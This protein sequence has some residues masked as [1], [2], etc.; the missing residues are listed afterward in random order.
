MKIAL[1]GTRGV[2][3]AYSGFETAIENIGPRLVARGH[4]VVVYCRP[5]MVERRLATYKGMHLVH[6][7]TIRTKHL[8]TFAHTLLSTGHMVTVERPDV[9]LY[10]IVGNS[11]FTKLSRLANV[12]AIIN[13]DGLD[14]LR[15]KWSPPAKAYLRWAERNAARFAD[16][17]ITDSSVVQDIYRRDYHADTVFIPYGAD[18]DGVD[19]GQCLESLGLQPRGYIL[20]VGRLEP[21]N[22][23]H[24]LVEAFAELHTDLRLV[25]VGDAPYA[26]KYAEVL[27]KLAASDPRVLLAGPI[28]GEGYRE[29]ARNA[30]LFVV[31]SE[32]GGTHPV[33][34][35]AMMA[36]NCVVVN[37][38]LPN[39]EVVGEAAVG[40]EGRRGALALTPVLQRLLDQPDVVEQY[41]RAAAQ[42]AQS[43]YSWDVVTDSYE[44]LAREVV[45]RHRAA[46]EGAGPGI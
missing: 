35:E 14:S 40:Y 34:I 17:V 2:P 3:A 11:P 16:V 39:L 22:N 28:Y 7:P 24:V 15:A 26:P 36:G 25:V 45:E 12:P 44:R 46:Q 18:M 30:T 38:H 29:L 13:V 42:Y 27:H 8:D 4:E 5:H 6:L 20:F 32:V 41:R 43:I 9:A 31:P 33:I 10:F 23:A 1:I 19:S 37:D 21:E